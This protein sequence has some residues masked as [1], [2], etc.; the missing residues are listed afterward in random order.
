MTSAKNEGSPTPSVVVFGPDGAIYEL[1]R[2]VAEKFECEQPSEKQKDQPIPSSPAEKANQEPESLSIRENLKLVWSFRPFFIPFLL[3]ALGLLLFALLQADIQLGAASFQQAL[4]DSL[5]PKAGVVAESVESA[6]PDSP[7]PGTRN[8]TGPTAGFL[9]AFLP[10][11]SGMETGTAAIWLSSFL[12]ISLIA[13][14]GSEQASVVLNQRFRHKVQ[15]ALLD[16]LARE[17]KEARSTR[18]SGASASVFRSDSGGLSGLVIFGVL[19]FLENVVRAVT[20]GF[21]IFMLPGGWLILL[22]IVPLAALFQTGVLALF[23]RAEAAATEQSEKLL[24][25][26]ESRTTRLLEMLG[27]FV[28]FGSDARLSQEILKLNLESAEANRRFQLISSL[29]NA[30]SGLILTFSLPLTVLLILWANEGGAQAV[31][32]GQ[33][34]AANFLVGMLLSN[35]SMI[36]MTPTTLTHYGPAMRR[37]RGIIDTPHVEVEPERLGEVVAQRTAPRLEVHNLE[38]SFRRTGA[39]VL[40]DVSFEIPSGAVIGIVGPSGCGKSTLASIL[41]GDLLPSGGSILY[42]GVDV[43]HWDLA[44]KR[45]IIG[46][47]PTAFEFINASVRENILLGRSPEEAPY[48]DLAVEK[49]GILEFLSATKPPRNLEFQIESFTGEGFL[50]SGQRRRVG[51]AQAIAGPQK[52]MILDEPGANL[53]PGDMVRV[54]ESMP[55]ALAGRTVIMI[56]HDPDVFLTDNI[57]F[58]LDGTIAAIGTHDELMAT[59]ED[60]RRIVSRNREERSVPEANAV[61]PSA[62]TAPSP[63]PPAG[64]KEAYRQKAK[65]KT[66]T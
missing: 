34:V 11:T 29:R 65:S 32:P 57:L 41:Q 52:L 43:T 4:I 14:I 45:R 3:P 64:S 12:L 1:P 62:P 24:M 5:M 7:D 15:E 33:V 50:S 49:A 60:Y 66:Q 48:L 28:S 54:A 30:V 9:S 39:K 63:A 38:F 16:G 6:N 59:N 31:N 26:V 8:E 27:R 10:A 36:M 46:F 2:E 23:H 20:L 44:W 35:I 51:L 21:G 37:L 25:L 53:N 40:R 19:G 61:M 18:Q 56:T 13:A 55:A 17:R 47:M 58:M 22:V 42:D